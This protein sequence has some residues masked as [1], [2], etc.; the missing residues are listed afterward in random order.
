MI[1]ILRGSGHDVSTVFDPK[2]FKAWESSTPT[3]E[4]DDNI[5]DTIIKTGCQALFAYTLSLIHI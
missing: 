3:S 1:S 5:V 2:G 4:L